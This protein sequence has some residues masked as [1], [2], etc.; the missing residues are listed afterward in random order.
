MSYDP[1]KQ[2]QA[3]EEALANPSP[4][5]YWNEMFVP[6]FLVVDVRGD[7]ITVLS[8][9][10]GPNSYNRKDEPN[11]YVD[12]GNNGWSFD[13]SKSMVVDRAWLAQAVKYSSIDGFVADVVNS[14]KTRSIAG[15]W[16]EH[17]RRSML[18]EIQ[19]LEEEYERFTG[20][21]YLKEGIK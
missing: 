11:A 10:G 2:R 8:C 9:M 15:S 14:E 21:K 16:R 20:W 17:R 5:D 18:E 19:R 1:D 13:V 6:Y 12:L 7:D 3:N 4:G